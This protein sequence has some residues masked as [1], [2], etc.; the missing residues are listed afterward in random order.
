MNKHLTELKQQKD[1]LWLNTVSRQCLANSIANLDEAYNRFFNKKAEHPRFKNR[2]SKQAFKICAFFSRILEDQIHLPVIGNIKC[3][4]NLSKEYKLNSITIIKTTTDKYFASISVEEEIPDPVANLKKP[5]IGID[6][7]LKTFITISDGRK[8]THPKPFNKLL[9]KIR[10]FCRRMSRRKLEKIQVPNNKKLTK[11]E[12]S[13]KHRCNT[14]TKTIVSNRRAIA[15]RK[16]A[17]LHA[18]IGNMR[19]DF[20]HK[21]SS[22]MV[23]ESQ[24]IYLEDLNLKGMM[25][26]YGKGICDSGWSE[27]SRQLGYKGNWYGCHTQKLISG[28]QA[29]RCAIGARI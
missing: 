3:E 23:D 26:R 1:Y 9:K 27:F 2:H 4:H 12:K 20:L 5:E 19:L 22:K 25:S 10:R 13:E 14:I 29:V 15:K 18:K 6:F 24:A 28:S 11:Q 7:G 17:I 16:L 21:L 8:I